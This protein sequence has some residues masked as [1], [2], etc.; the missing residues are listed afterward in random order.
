MDE[1]F[2]IE[3]APRGDTGELFDWSEDEWRQAIKLA[4][5]SD[6]PGSG[7]AIIA[8]DGREIFNP[9]PVAPPIGWKPEP[10]MFQIMKAMVQRELAALKGD[11][12]AETAEEAEDFVVDEDFD[13]MSIYEVVDMIPDPGP[14]P[15]PAPVETPIA[16]SEQA[17][18][19]SA[20]ASP[21]GG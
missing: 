20:P 17:P 1:K 2:K 6:D 8:P 11:E 4:G 13:P 9:V 21:P 3:V 19:P 5:W 15:Q 14:V 7:K 12:I 10:D 16:P 18:A